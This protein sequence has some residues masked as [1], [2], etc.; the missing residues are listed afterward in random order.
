[1]YTFQSPA[2]ICMFYFSHPFGIASPPNYVDN[3]KMCSQE[4]IKNGQINYVNCKSK[5]NHV[6]KKKNVSA[7]KK[8]TYIPWPRDTWR[9]DYILPPL[10]QM[11]AKQMGELLLYNF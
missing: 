6:K 3:N 7:S 11:L 2:P 1:M 4:Q 9:R 5:T 8:L 10:V